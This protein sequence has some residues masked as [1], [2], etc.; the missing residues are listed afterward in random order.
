MLSRTD[1]A[2]WSV[3][4]VVVVT[5]VMLCAPT[6]WGKGKPPANQPVTATFVSTPGVG[7]T[8]DSNGDYPAIFDQNGEF[9]LELPAGG[10]RWVTLN[11]NDRIAPGSCGSSCFF[12]G[13][14]FPA[15]NIGIGKHGHL[16]TNLV[17]AHGNEVDGGSRTCRRA[18]G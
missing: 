4:L 17:D 14:L 6:G 8:G 11:F 7:I 13:S 12:N 10:P 9:Y 5:A 3:A 2:R 15:V 18:R 16:W 1:R